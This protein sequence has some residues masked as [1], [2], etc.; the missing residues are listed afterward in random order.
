M[1]KNKKIL[2]IIIPLVII[3]LGILVLCIKGMNYGLMYGENTQ[4]KVYL[5]SEIED[6]SNLVTEVFGKNKI[7]KLNGVNTDI[8]ITVK[9]ASE[10]Q[11]DSFVTKVNE[12]NGIELTRDD[13]EVSNNA[14]IKGIDLISPYI[15]PSVITSVLVLIYFVIR[16]KKFGILK[17]TIYT[18][19]VLIGAQLLYLSIYAVARIPVNYWSMPIS[20]I[21][22]VLSIIGLLEFFE[23]NN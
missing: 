15:L 3:L 10:E 8:L 17:I 18:L 23:K 22:Y 1:L 12:N 7:Q 6:V 19:T 16:Y 4:I 14:K 11:L 9:E 2:F 21:I 13:L 5:D 20:M